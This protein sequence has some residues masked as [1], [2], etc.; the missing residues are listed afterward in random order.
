MLD[1]TSKL[2]GVAVALL[3]T[4]TAS[5]ASDENC[6]DSLVRET[7]TNRSVRQDDR[8]LSTLVT[9]DSW[10]EA[11]NKSGANGKLF[12]VTIG[13]SYDDYKANSQSTLDRR[14]EQET[15]SEALNI[16][17]TGLD[18]EASKRYQDCLRFKLMTIDGLQAAVIGAT[19]SDITI[20]VH[21]HVTGR[22]RAARVD[23]SPSSLGGQ[24]IQQLIPDGYTT[25]R[26]RRPTA[27]VTLAGNSGGY[28]TQNIVLTPLRRDVRE[29]PTTADCPGRHLVRAYNN[30]PAL[31]LDID[32]GDRGDGE[33]QVN[34]QARR[35]FYYA[36][37]AGRHWGVDVNSAG[38]SAPRGGEIVDGSVRIERVEANNEISGFSAAK[39]GANSIDLYFQSGTGGAPRSGV[40]FAV[41]YTY[42]T[43]SPC[44]AAMV[45]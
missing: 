35:G 33:R 7:Y 23:W 26:V 37:G 24:L 29:V 42:R 8:R 10:T 2:L 4:T 5:W 17:W 28:T 41:Y 13:G 6:Q 31:S 36:A 38:W 34:A 12:G 39:T 14:S 30:Y 15:H 20:L 22:A 3:L 43:A 16:A 27:T 9:S 18:G 40:A 21:Y 11:H 19:E 45:Q 1:I 44:E 25:I 32:P